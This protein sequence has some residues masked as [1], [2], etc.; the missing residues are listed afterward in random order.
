MER[1][2]II[3]IQSVIE[4]TQ[5]ASFPAGVPILPRHRFPEPSAGAIT[6]TKH[7][8]GQDFWEP[9]SSFWKLFSQC[10]S[11]QSYVQLKVS[12]V[13]MWVKAGLCLL[14]ASS[15][16]SPW[17]LGPTCLQ[18]FIFGCTGLPKFLLDSLT[19]FGCPFLRRAHIL[20]LLLC[21][22]TGKCS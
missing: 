7:N 15:F 2:P 19:S 5:Q 11:L 21:V 12:V 13:V 14:G 8:S 1:S 6:T 16:I 22:Q 10:L 18:F 3:A 4:M 20:R 9:W 17:D